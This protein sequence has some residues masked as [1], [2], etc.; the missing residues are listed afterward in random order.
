M[1]PCVPDQIGIWKYWFLRRGEDCRT[2][3]K[4]S[5]SKGENG[6]KNKLNPHTVYGV[7]TRMETRATLVVEAG[8]LTTVP[9]LLLLHTST[10]NCTV[11]LP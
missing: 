5:W 11:S 2:R 6:T 9:P 1:R 4:T 10:F 7:D 3:R 8:A